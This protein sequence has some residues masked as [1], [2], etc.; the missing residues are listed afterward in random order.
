MNSIRFA[1]RGLLQHTFERLY[2]FENIQPVRIVI[3]II[4]IRASSSLVQIIHTRHGPNRYE[5]RV[6]A[7]RRSRGSPAR[8]V[9]NIIILSCTKISAQQ[10][11]GKKIE[12]YNI[13][14]HN[15][16]VIL[17]FVVFI[18]LLHATYNI[19]HTQTHTSCA[20]DRVCSVFAT[21][22]NIYIPMTCPR[23]G[24]SE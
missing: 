3:I 1:R 15:I 14:I 5:K 9:Y 11:P 24:V 20:A 21:H 16:I 10:R 4:I 22:A 13:N 23:S 17:M 2:S 7:P 6:A 12:L 19:I 8:R 18:H